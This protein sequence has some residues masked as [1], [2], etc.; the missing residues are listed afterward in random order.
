MGIVFQ[1]RFFTFDA[2]GHPAG[3]GVHP[4]PVQY[5]AEIRVSD[6]IKDD[7]TGVHRI[8]AFRQLDLDGLGV[9]A[10]IS[11]GLING[12]VKVPVQQV[13]GRKPRNARTDN[14]DFH[15]NTGF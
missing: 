10:H 5:P 1:P 13:S 6:F 2:E 8:A 4:Q 7:E 14:G 11:V 9:P 12:E 3:L 15:W